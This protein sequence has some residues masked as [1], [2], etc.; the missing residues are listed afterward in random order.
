MERRAW[1]TWWVIF[2]N[3]YSKLLLIYLKKTW[4]KTD[5][6]AIKIY[7]NKIENRN[8]LKIK[9]G[10][11]FKLLSPKSMKLLRSSKSKITK[12]KIVTMCLI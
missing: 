12:E 6:P 2:F 7:L 8:T 4:E 9:K 3:R 10:Y 1:I 11:Y 5:N